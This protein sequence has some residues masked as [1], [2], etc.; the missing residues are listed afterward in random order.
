MKLLPNNEIIGRL[1][2]IDS[3]GQCLNLVVSINREIE[4]P[5]DAFSHDELKK[6][7]DRMIGI[8][9]FEGKLFL[10]EL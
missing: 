7:L 8:L 2:K 3:D 9:N 1:S 10:R 4:I 6:Y 5:V